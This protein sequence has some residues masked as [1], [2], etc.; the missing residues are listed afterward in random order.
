MNEKQNCYIWQETML[1]QSNE[2]FKIKKFDKNWKKKVW[3]KYIHIRVTHKYVYGREIEMQTDRERRDELLSKRFEKDYKGMHYA[4]ERICIES[5]NENGEKRKAQK[6]T[7][8]L[9]QRFDA[10]AFKI[11]SGLRKA[12]KG[13]SMD[14]MTKEA[15]GLN[16]QV[17]LTK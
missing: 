4:W 11:Q 3:Y 17:T 12:V 7:G 16:T 10:G 13:R 15:W 9:K 14:T 5:C 8:W 1:L 6:I 2:N